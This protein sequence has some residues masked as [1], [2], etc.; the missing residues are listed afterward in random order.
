MAYDHL[1]DSVVST[2]VM[3]NP[4]TGEYFETFENQLPPPNTTRH[5]LHSHQL[6]HINPRL[7]QLLGVDT[8]K[9]APRKEEVLLQPP[10]GL[11]GANTQ[12][13]QVYGAGINSQLRMLVS[14]DLYNCRDGDHAVEPSMAGEQPDGYVGYVKRHRF[15]PHMPPTQAL[16]HGGR[17]QP[18]QTR[19]PDPIKQRLSTPQVFARKARVLVQD[20]KV[21]PDGLINGVSAVS[22][23]PITTDATG[24]QRSTVQSYIATCAPVVETVNAR[25]ITSEHHGRVLTDKSTPVRPQTL[26]VSEPIQPSQWPRQPNHSE[27]DTGR[28][29]G[30][31]YDES[32]AAH[33]EPTLPRE[34]TRPG[35]K[36]GSVAARLVVD[37]DSGETLTQHHTIRNS[38]K[39]TPAGHTRAPV[40][41]QAS[42]PV[43]TKQMRVRETQRESHVAR[44]PRVVAIA[45]ETPPL[46]M[47]AS[48]TTSAKDSSHQQRRVAATAQTEISDTRVYN[49][50]GANPVSR[51][52]TLV[53]TASI[54]GI[55]RSN[56]AATNASIRYTLKAA[57]LDGSSRQNN[58]MMMADD[59]HRVSTCAIR[60]V[61]K[62]QM[63]DNC[64]RPNAPSTLLAGAIAMPID[65]PV[66]ATTRSDNPTRPISVQRSTDGDTMEPAQPTREVTKT[67]TSSRLLSVQQPVDGNIMKPTQPTREVTKTDTSSR[68]L[69]VQ[70][71]TDGDSME[72]TQP[73]R[74]VTK[75]DTSSR[76]LSVQQSTDGDSMEPTRPTR[77]VTGRDTSSRLLSVQQSTDGDI[78]EPTRPTREATETDTSSRLL[79]VQ[80]STDGDIMEPTRPTREVMETDT[81]PRPIS[82][83]RST[84]AD[85]M[86]PAHSV[87]NVTK[88]DTDNAFRSNPGH[89]P[90]S[91]NSTDPTQFSRAAK[92]TDAK[93]NASRLTSV[94]AASVDVDT[95][96]NIHT[97]RSVKT[98]DITEMPFHF[99]T[100]TDAIQDVETSRCDV[101]LK[102]SMKAHILDQSFRL[103]TDVIESS[104]VRGARIDCVLKETHRQTNERINRNQSI[105]IDIGD[106]LTGHETPVVL[107]V[108]GLKE[109]D[110]TPVTRIVDGTDGS[111]RVEQTYT[112]RADPT[113]SPN[114]NSDLIIKRHNIGRPI[115]PFRENVRTAPEAPHE[116]EY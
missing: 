90:G 40:H 28:T 86:K 116:S 8:S 95:R 100:S 33:V 82:V 115:L 109:Q 111:D 93:D 23:V 49:S 88:S 10:S 97:L 55:N 106:I 79:S 30:H 53:P 2:G 99:N 98:T 13:P 54:T 74:E 26:V 75:T 71:S 51:I 67:D 48:Q 113:P 83:Q 32:V 112:I 12:G 72:P 107:Q 114:I 92:R 77:E 68:L 25:P 16:D 66:H 59:N 91:H 87:K 27:H 110:Y 17:T 24:T 57:I 7:V 6:A 29:A 102:P 73:T 104:D 21:A 69:S 14:R 9:Q 76:L 103:N 19:N 78:M 39:D 89:I 4:Y 84:D 58:V 65:R 43:R 64:A 36:D 1:T 94:D 35:N 41:N 81:P 70:Q 56:I 18:L 60:P 5:V 101:T 46:A 44:Q 22:V 45:T 20:R 105:H 52:E 11:A 62:T 108:R 63:L 50:I 34:S 37:R 61:A 96:E 38:A 31:P 3:K 80:Q 15:R 47:P 42:N 85:I